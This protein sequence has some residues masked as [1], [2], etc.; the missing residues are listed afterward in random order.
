MHTG[1]VLRNYLPRSFKLALFDQEW[2]HIQAIIYR[3]GILEHI[4]HGSIITYSGVQRQSIF[5]LEGVEL[6]DAPFKWA[7]YDLVFFHSL[8][9]IIYYFAPPHAYISHLFAFM[10]RIYTTTDITEKEKKI[11]LCQLFAL[12]GVYPEDASITFPTLFLLISSSSNIMLNKSLDMVS[13]NELDNWIKQCIAM[14]P[15]AQKINIRF[16]VLYAHTT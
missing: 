8:L 2:G 6:I 16:P 5:V 3:K 4:M 13:L 14:H 7:L 15:H 1:I 9:E 12:L 10:I 11:V